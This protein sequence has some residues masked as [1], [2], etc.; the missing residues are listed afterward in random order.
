M[1]GGVDEAHMK[2][3]KNHILQKSK[4]KDLSTVTS[5]NLW[6]QELSDISCLPSV[7]PGLEVLSLV[8]NSLS[9]ITPLAGLPRLREL[10]LRDN[11]VDDWE[12]VWSALGGLPRLAELSLGE[13]P[14]SE[15][16]YFEYRAM[17]VAMMPRLRVIDGIPVGELE[18]E[19]AAG[20]HPSLS[21]LAT[22]AARIV[23]LDE[24][25]RM[26]AGDEEE[27]EDED[28]TMVVYPQA[29]GQQEDSDLEF[30]VKISHIDPPQQSALPEME[31]EESGLGEK[32]AFSKK[33]L[34]QHS[35]ASSSSS[36]SAY[37][38]DSVAGGAPV[39]VKPSATSTRKQRVAPLDGRAAAKHRVDARQTDQE[40]PNHNILVASLTLLREMDTISL[41]VLKQEIETLLKVQKASFPES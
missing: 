27:E 41:V 1:L 11:R 36:S 40:G 26:A 5:L 28:R 3:T 13:N 20:V 17:L 7:C 9:D 34:V 35:S 15:P 30:D 10:H 16:E 39:S 29:L 6:G 18:R 31:E 22:G 24:Y 21:L 19:E 2:L 38:D 37:S 33:G 12:V 14:V 25:E 8:V 32:D 4:N 23:T